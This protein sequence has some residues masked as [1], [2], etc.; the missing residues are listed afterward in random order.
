MLFFLQHLF[1][2]RCHHPRPPR[3]RVTL[4]VHRCH[5][6]TVMTVMTVTHMTVMASMAARRG[7]LVAPKVASAQLQ[8]RREREPGH[9]MFFFKK[10]VVCVCVKGFVCKRYVYE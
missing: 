1:P 2:V 6:M 7:A 3:L 8:R 4:V 5:R 10:D 9:E